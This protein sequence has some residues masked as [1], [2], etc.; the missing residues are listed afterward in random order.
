MYKL[1]LWKSSYEWY[2]IRQYMK[3][4]HLDIQTGEFDS[5]QL[6]LKLNGLQIIA[7]GCGADNQIHSTHWKRRVTR[8]PKKMESK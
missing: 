1:R 4:R 3:R 7:D 8:F 2:S 5:K 6:I